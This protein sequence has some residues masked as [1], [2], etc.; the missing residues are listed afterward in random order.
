MV[1]IGGYGAFVAFGQCARVAEWSGDCR[2]L[3]V[4]DVVAPECRENG[5]V[6]DVRKPGVAELSR[7]VVDEGDVVC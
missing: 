2:A 5:G 6:V 1:G 7:D 3:C 4:E